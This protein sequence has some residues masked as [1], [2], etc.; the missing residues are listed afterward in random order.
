[1]RSETV[2]FWE[3]AA[4]RLSRLLT[5]KNDNVYEVTMTSDGK[6]LASGGEAG[7]KLWDVA[8][9]QQVLSI[10]GL[11]AEFAFSPDNKLLAIA[12][13]DDVPGH[14]R[15]INFWEVATGKRLPAP[16]IEFV[17]NGAPFRSELAFSPDGKTLAYSGG[18]N[19][20]ILWDIATGQQL[21]KLTGHSHHVMTNTFSPDGR[22]LATGS[23]DKTVG[24]WDVATGQRLQTLETGS[25]ESE[26]Y[27]VRFSPDG[28]TLL[29]GSRDH[30]I[31]V[32]D[33]NTG[34]LLRVLEGHT[35]SVLSISLS[36]DGKLLASGSSDGSIRLWDV[37]GGRE[38]ASLYAL[39]NTEWAVITK[40]GRFDASP[41][42]MELMHW[43]VGNE[44]VSLN[45]LKERYYEPHL[46]PKL[47][48]YNKEPLRNISAFTEVKLFPE[49]SFNSPQPGGTKLTVKLANRG[50]GIGR[51]RVLVNGKEI[52]ADAR[53]PKPDPQAAHAELTVDLA[54][55]PVIPGQENRIQVVAW[56]SEGYLS[57]RGTQI[58]WTPPKQNDDPSHEPQLYAIVAGISDYSNPQMNLSFA[59]K[60]AEDMAK[61][62]EIGAK[63]LFGVE[64]TH[65]TL[66]TTT[67]KAGAL[68]PTKE[69]FRKAFADIAAKAKP[70]DIFV[71]YMAGHGVALAGTEDVYLY[72]TQEARTLDGAA[73]A[74]KSL[75]EA[76]TVSSEELVDWIKRVQALK[77]VMVLDTCAAGAAASKLVEKRDVSS[78]QIRAIERLKDRTGFYVLM[79]SAGDAVSYEASQYGQGLLTYSLLQG[80]KGGALREDQYVD[81]SALFQ[82]AADQVPL[83]ARNIGGIQRPII[84]SPKGSS[85][86]VGLLKTKEERAAIP[87]AQVRPLVLR[88]VLLNVEQGFDDLE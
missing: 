55:A 72:P 12:S 19:S 3:P 46:L 23:M 30:T 51:V 6:L 79:G 1:D 7:I 53:G 73:L 59:S 76:T 33:V 48:G 82:Y 31:K 49:V 34:R 21:H 88:P 9:G 71:V 54:G 17:W 77:Q 41:K 25:G 37:N 84:A 87:L 69:N 66:L 78:D 64:K 75:R 14:V 63:G 8:T 43:V 56:N 28:Q 86:D 27:T 10:K 61:A 80:M 44:V 22:L 38:I 16:R 67:G 11:F 50:G 45:Q 81:V 47:L 83:L 85:F 74:D 2:Q 29:G 24:L 62:F 18:D 36:A 65:I 57:S 35:D 39:D 58:V 68:Q 32:W 5:D 40:D 60:D 42:A 70:W 20:V 26:L 4:G 52:V 15:T 13:Y